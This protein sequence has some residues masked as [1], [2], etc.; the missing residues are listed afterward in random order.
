MST[1]KDVS[2]YTGL[3]VATISKYLNGAAVRAKNRDL[4]DAAVKA[5]D[6]QVNPFARSL[7]TRKSNTVGALLPALNAPFFGNM[8]AAIDGALRKA[9]LNLVISCYDMDEA[10]ERKKLEAFMNGG[11]DGLIYAPEH[12]DKAAY[13]RITAKRGIPVVMVDRIIAE[14]SVDT[15][16]L[17]NSQAIYAAAEQLISKGHARIGF[18]TGQPDIFTAAERQMGLE[19]ALGDYNIAIDTGLIKHGSYTVS[20][21]YRLFNELLELP[22]P[23]TAVITGNYDLTLGAI[24]AAKDK[25]ITLPYDLDFFGFDCTEVCRLMNPPLPT[26]EQPERKIGELAA[27]YI[28]ERLD[29]E[30]SPPRLTR[31]KAILHAV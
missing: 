22:S 19:R 2:E 30:A 6:Y 29:G 21:G 20:D 5:L 13:E 9:E 26:I 7:K 11:I 15:V 24:T 16:L 17:G 27:Q 1:I 23:P 14:L 18:I 12:V 25:G 3:S 28:M 31:L 4:I 10:L 8:L